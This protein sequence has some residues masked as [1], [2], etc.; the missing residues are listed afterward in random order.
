MQS[1]D[2]LVHDGL[3]ADAVI[4]QFQIEAVRAE[5]LRYVQR[6]FLGVVILAIAQTAG[7]SPA[8]HADRA[9]SP[10]R[11]RAA[12]QVDPGFR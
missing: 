8:R 12:V 2:A 5:Q 3:I 11:V 10:R 1:Q 7:I 9:I 4:L 6:V